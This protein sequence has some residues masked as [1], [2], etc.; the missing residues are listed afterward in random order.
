MN[1]R[2]LTHERGELT[3]TFL[4]G[5]GQLARGPGELTVHQV[6]P[7][8]GWVDSALGLNRPQA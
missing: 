4:N 2:E 8:P 7:A 6:N 3:R 1:P 5:G